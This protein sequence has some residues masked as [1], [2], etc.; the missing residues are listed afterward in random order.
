MQ[1]FVFKTRNPEYSWWI[2][3]AIGI[4]LYAHIY[5]IG[6]KF[7][8]NWFLGA[9]LGLATNFFFTSTI[10]IKDKQIAIKKHFM[11][12]IYYKYKWTFE[13]IIFTRGNCIEFVNQNN[14]V[15]CF[16]NDDNDSYDG[17]ED[18]F[19]VKIS[20]RKIILGGS[21]KDFTNFKESLEEWTE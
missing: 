20:N 12:V 16:F 15:I 8:M 3:G 13:Y 5:L 4:S 21:K 10:M 2:F 9:I 11:A 19:V 1:N 17:N 14:E 6:D 18:E 7:L